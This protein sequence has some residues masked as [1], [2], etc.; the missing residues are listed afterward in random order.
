MICYAFNI[1]QRTSPINTDFGEI[2][3]PILPKM[4]IKIFEEVGDLLLTQKR[5][6]IIIGTNI[7]SESRYEYEK[8]YAHQQYKY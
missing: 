2:M 7:F 5:L 8:D 6:I 4:R 3:R 1:N